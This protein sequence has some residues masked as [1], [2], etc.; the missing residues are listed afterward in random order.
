MARKSRPDWLDSNQGLCYHR[1]MDKE[2]KWCPWHNGGL[3]QMRP[4]AEFGPNRQHNPNGVQGQCRECR[5][6]HK[7]GHYD[8]HGTSLKARYAHTRTQ[9]HRRGLRFTL[10]REQ[11]AGLVSQP[12]TYAVQAESAIQTGL[13]RKDSSKGYTIT[14]V[15]PCC[16]RHNL[17]KGDFLTPEQTRDASQR[18]GIRCG[19]TLAGRHKL[20]RERTADASQ[21]RSNCGETAKGE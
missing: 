3:G 8:V 15:L 17:F 20:P 16:A 19:N 10:T 14:N 21:N 7:R 5:R 18:Y 4:I 13:D 2:T 6:L 12:C 11:F 1:A 9:A